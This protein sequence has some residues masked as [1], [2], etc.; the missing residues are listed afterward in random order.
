MYWAHK[1]IDGH[2]VVQKYKGVNQI[3]EQYKSVTN[4]KIIMP[5][6]A[7]DI[8]DAAVQ[9]GNRLEGGRFVL[10]E[11]LESGVEIPKRYD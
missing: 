11:R 6:E 4:A 9:A 2:I 3:K 7:K 1:D 5:Y 8:N 10:M